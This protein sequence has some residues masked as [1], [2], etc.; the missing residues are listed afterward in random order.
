MATVLPRV[1]RGVV[2]AL[3]G[4]GL[5]CSILALA[6]LA[7]GPRTGRY[8]MQTVLTGSMRPKLPVGSL[9]IST[10]EP[11][12][13]VRAGQIITFQAPVGNWVVTHRV[14][15]VVSGG[16]HPRVRTKGDANAAADPWV[17][18]LERGPVWRVRLVVPLLG[19]AVRFL[20]MRWVHIGTVL[21]APMLLVLLGL[22]TIWA[23]DLF[24]RHVRRARRPPA[25]TS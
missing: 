16:P 5:A 19:T 11:L 18:Q 2:R 3:L 8:R 13:R 4:V 17:T 23:P 25:A 15:E 20:R 24:R 7:I 21:V 9:A 1:A 10:P 22:R 6:A 14:I 12:D